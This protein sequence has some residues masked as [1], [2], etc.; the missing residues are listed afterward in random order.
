[1]RSDKIEKQDP[2]KFPFEWIIIEKGLEEGKW[3]RSEL[4]FFDGT[5]TEFFQVQ[6]SSVTKDSFK[7]KS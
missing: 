5:R 4:T 1:M 7:L 2:W 6:D 3:L